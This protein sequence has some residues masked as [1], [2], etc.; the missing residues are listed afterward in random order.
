LL[1]IALGAVSANVLN[2]YSGAMV[3]FWARR[4][5]SVAYAGQR[6]LVAVLF[7]VIGYLVARAGEVDAG[8]AYENFLLLIGY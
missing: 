3:H 6:G 1:A 4:A 8:H 2:I 7:G 5:A